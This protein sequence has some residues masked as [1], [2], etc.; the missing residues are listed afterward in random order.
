MVGALIRRLR[1]EAGAA[2]AGTWIWT[3]AFWGL[4][5]LPN[6]Q[7]FHRYYE[8]A[9]V[10]LLI[11]WVLLILRSRTPSN[12]PRWLPLGALAVGQLVLTLVV[13]HYQVFWGHLL[14]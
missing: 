6:R 2:T 11:L 3:S 7:V 12:T 9:I 8:P 10:I 1:A 4:S 14:P 13:V 5:Q